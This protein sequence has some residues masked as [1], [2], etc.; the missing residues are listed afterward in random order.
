LQIG[1]QPLPK[2]SLGL[3]RGGFLREGIFESGKKKKRILKVNCEYNLTICVLLE[4]AFSGDLQT[5]HQD[6]SDICRAVVAHA[7]N[8]SIWEAEADGF[9]DS[10]P[11]WSTE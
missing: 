7:F 9:L 8:P 1:S 10:R 4:T 6:S 2:T 11:A 3:S 5:V